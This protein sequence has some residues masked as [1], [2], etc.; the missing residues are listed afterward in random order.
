MLTNLV[1]T[2]RPKIKVLP[3]RTMVTPL[4]S[5]TL[6]KTGIQ[7]INTILTENIW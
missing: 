4:T 6:L 1:I 2:A 3:N 7:L 5:R